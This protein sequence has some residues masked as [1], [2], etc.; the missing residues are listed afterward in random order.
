M[1][2][3]A[4]EVE[5]FW[6][7]QVPDQ[8]QAEALGGDTDR[9]SVAVHFCHPASIETLLSYADEDVSLQ[10]WSSACVRRL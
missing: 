3:L 8:A 10:L 6:P 1:V 4:V 7:V 5:P 9:V 2:A